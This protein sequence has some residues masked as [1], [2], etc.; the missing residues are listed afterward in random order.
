MATK[1]S[2]TT[3]TPGPGVVFHVDDGIAYGDLA[4]DTYMV[5]TQLVQ[6]E[7]YQDTLSRYFDVEVFDGGGDDPRNGTITSI[8]TPE[9]DA[10]GEITGWVHHSVENAWW[11]V[12]LSLGGETEGIEHFREYAGQAPDP[13]L[14]ALHHG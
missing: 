10:D 7:T 13:R 11:T 5:T 8:T 12:S 1:T 4:V 14:F 3:K 6:N 9:F 2:C